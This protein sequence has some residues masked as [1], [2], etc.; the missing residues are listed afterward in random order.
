[1]GLRVS[2]RYLEK[3]VFLKKVCQMVFTVFFFLKKKTNVEKVFDRFLEGWFGFSKR[4]F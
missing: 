4:C 1:M 2:Q 3:K